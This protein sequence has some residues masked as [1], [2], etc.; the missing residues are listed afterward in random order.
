MHQN[1]IIIKTTESGRKK[2]EELQWRKL[3]NNPNIYKINMC[4]HVIEGCKVIQA[5]SGFFKSQFKNNEKE[6]E[7][8]YPSFLVL[9]EFQ[10]LTNLRNTT[11]HTAL[12]FLYFSD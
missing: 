8:T 9:F 10:Y 5:S 1:D 11:Q 12:S 6:K 4:N 2:H 3:R 7:N